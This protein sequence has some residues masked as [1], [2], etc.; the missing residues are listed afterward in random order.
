MNFRQPQKNSYLIKIV[1]K[2]FWK[3]TK[4]HGS[5]EVFF[6]YHTQDLKQYLLCM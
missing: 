6:E 1:W 4:I 5:Y 3:P 2:T